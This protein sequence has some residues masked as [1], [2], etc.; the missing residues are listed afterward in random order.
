MVFCFSCNSGSM[1]KLCK[2]DKISTSGKIQIK[3]SNSL[4]NK[5][6]M[7]YEWTWNRPAELLVSSR[8][9]VS[10]VTTLA[11]ALTDAMSCL[12]Q[13]AVSLSSADVST[14]WWQGT[15]VCC[16]LLRPGRSWNYSAAEQMM[17]VVLH[18]YTDKKKSPLTLLP[19]VRERRWKSR[20]LMVHVLSQHVH[21]CHFF[22]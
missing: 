19:A 22:F 14:L 9:M 8:Q 3:N 5:N 7:T 18:Q 20:C 2:R 17:N 4:Q 1:N 10:S 11:T 13:L 12:V 16:L 21:C 6:K 15:L